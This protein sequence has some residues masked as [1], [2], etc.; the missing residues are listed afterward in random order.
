MKYNKVPEDRLVQQHW[1]VRDRNGVE[2]KGVIEFDSDAPPGEPNCRRVVL[3]DP[4]IFDNAY[5]PGAFV[6][7]EGTI[8]PSPQQ[9]EAKRNKIIL[10]TSPEANAGQI[11]QLSKEQT[12]KEEDIEKAKAAATERA[13]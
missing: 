11:N 5:I 1:K 9:L 4:Y 2:Q 3:N 7:I 13:K 10:G 6:E 8:N 12:K